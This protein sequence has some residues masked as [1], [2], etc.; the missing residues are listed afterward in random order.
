MENVRSE[1]G[2]CKE[3]IFEELFEKC[4]SDED[5]ENG[6]CVE[7]DD[8]DDNTC[9]DRDL[10]NNCII[11]EVED[12][13]VVYDP[14]DE[15]KIIDKDIKL[16]GQS[17]EKITDNSWLIYLLIGVGALIVLILIVLMVKG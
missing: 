2:E 6:E 3:N 12:V 17:K 4:D 8:D 15:E 11:D 13:L 10:Y 7:E 16:G 14:L 5:C 9:N 1:N